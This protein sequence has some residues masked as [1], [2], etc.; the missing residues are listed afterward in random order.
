ML[1]LSMVEVADDY[2]PLSALNDLLFCTRRCFLHRVEGVWVENAHTSAGSQD[3]RRVHETRDSEAS[4]GKTS[5]GLRLI[6]H[7]LRIQ[8]VADLVE[9]SAG[10]PYPVEYKRGRRRK[11][12]NDEVQLCAQAICLEEMMEVTIP[13][14][15]IF[16]VL[17]KRRREVEFTPSLRQQ[18]QDAARRL[19]ELLK[20]AQ[21]P[22]AVLHKKCQGCSLHELCLPELLS[23]PVSYLKAAKTLFTA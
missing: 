20:Q 2:P 23:A 10:V 12:D 19:H 6:S 14:G 5:R 22:A 21:A 11:W 7:T 3:H 15:A 17:T 9:F 16:H 8:G 18:T 4:S 1:T 13:A